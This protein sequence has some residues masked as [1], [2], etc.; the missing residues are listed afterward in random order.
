[1]GIAMKKLRVKL[2]NNQHIKILFQLFLKKNR[3]PLQGNQVVDR[4]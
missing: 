1:M 4:L 2:F 3:S